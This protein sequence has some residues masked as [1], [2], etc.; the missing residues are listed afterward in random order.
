MTAF[1]RISLKIDSRLDCVSLVSASI[2]VLC[3]ENG[4]N[5]MNSYQVQ[6]ATTE[7]INNAI[8]HAYES[9]PGQEVTVDWI[10]DGHTIRIE[11]SDNGKSMAQIPPDIEPLPEA[12]S[13][14]GWW[15]M[16]RWMDHVD[17][18]SCDGLNRIIL[19]RKI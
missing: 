13:G 12:E 1:K 10:L 2:N 4:M 8:I 5:E 9:Q 3:R 6:T 14:R 16:R 11:V 7:A 19:Q 18:A 17:Y 15:I